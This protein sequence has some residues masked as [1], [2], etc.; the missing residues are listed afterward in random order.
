MVADAA[1]PEP[2]VLLG[3]PVECKS[4]PPAREASPPDDLV[5]PHTSN[6]PGSIDIDLPTGVRLMVDSYVNEKGAGTR[7]ARLAGSVVISLAP[8]TKVYLASK[9]VSMRQ[10]SDGLPALA[11]PL[12]VV[13]PYTG[14]VFLFRSRNGNYLKACAGTAL[15]CACSPSGRSGTASLGHR[16]RTRAWC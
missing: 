15:A 5:R 16:W 6:R 13:E 1:P 8:G 3:T 7:A 11:Q 14:H 9:P 12:F 10:G 2:V 4:T